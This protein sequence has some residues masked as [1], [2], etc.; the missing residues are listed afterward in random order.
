MKSVDSNPDDK[1]EED[2]PD[3]AEDGDHHDESDYEF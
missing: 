2:V 1:Y 3:K